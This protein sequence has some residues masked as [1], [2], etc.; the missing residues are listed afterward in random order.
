MVVTAS[1]AI[2]AVG[3][4][5]ASGISG[6]KAAKAAKK[7]AKYSNMRAV[8]VDKETL[9]NQ[10]RSARAARAESLALST[11]AGM[12]EGSA[13]VGALSSIGSQYSHN[14]L[15]TTNDM[16]YQKMIAKYKG[17]VSNYQNQSG[18][19]SSISDL[20]KTAAVAS[21]SGD[22][23]GTGSGGVSESGGYS[24]SGFSSSGS[25]GS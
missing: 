21:A 22:F 15:F 6:N 20:F 9:I 19:Y 3:T 5:V 8:A 10:V 23:D 7:A 16:W 2:A 11:Q 1:L 24:S 17:Q 14:M 12:T 25:S 13:S 18:L 4:A